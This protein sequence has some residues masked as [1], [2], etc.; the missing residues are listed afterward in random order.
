MKP[1]III[2]TNVVF[3]A[4]RSLNGASNKLMA[5]VGTKKFR[6]CVSVP[7]ILEY[8]EVL[9]RSSE[10]FGKARIEQYLDYICY[11]SEHIQIHF[12]WRPFLKD[13]DDD[14]LLE[15]AVAAEADYIVTYN[16]DDFQGIQKFKVEAIR[17]QQFLQII[18][19]L[20]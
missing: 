5:L 3:S 13:S 17:P 12:L 6:P 10:R 16:I 1:K 4:L 19:E 8:E 11:A 7:L 9:L 14:M 18:G 20:P 15:L 2:D